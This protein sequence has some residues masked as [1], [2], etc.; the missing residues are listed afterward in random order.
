[1][2]VSSYFRKIITMFKKIFTQL[3]VQ[4]AIAS[5]DL[6]VDDSPV[7]IRSSSPPRSRSSTVQKFAEP[8]TSSFPP[9]V[10]PVMPPAGSTSR[11]T[12]R[13]LTS[14][15]SKANQRYIHINIFFRGNRTEYILEDNQTIGQ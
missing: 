15:G 10:N 2:S 6:D 9:M 8:S 4:T 5:Q 11:S 12:F 14:S 1:M 7:E 13:K 3:A